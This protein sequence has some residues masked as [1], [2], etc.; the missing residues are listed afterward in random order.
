MSMLRATPVHAESPRYAAPLL[1]LPELW[2]PAEVWLPVASFLGHRGWES[3]LIHLRGADDLAARVAGV[4]EH[5]R[6]LPHPPILIGHGGGAVVAM[7]CARAG[8]VAAAVLVAPLVPGRA[9]IGVLTR[10]WDAVAALLLGR[11]LPPPRGESARRV[12]GEVPDGLDVEPA[13]AVF[14]V[15]RGRPGELR[16]LGMPTL[17]VAGT[18]DPLLPRDAAMALAAA[19]GAEQTE[20]EGAAHWPIVAPAWQ[21]TADVVHRWLVR[22][23][24]EPL[25]D[26]YAEMMAERDAAD[27]DDE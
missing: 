6:R 2:A 8:P 20:I 7:G 11:A 1:F 27:V 10:R 4:I 15:V 22:R 5:A 23:L 12:F 26:L 13:R 18:R 14:D 24:G 17:M 16:P 9:R 21:H 3:E 25:L 19:L